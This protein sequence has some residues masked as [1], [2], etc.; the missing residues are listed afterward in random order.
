MAPSAAVTLNDA[1][2]QDESLVLSTVR[3]AAIRGEPPLHSGG[4]RLVIID[5][6]RALH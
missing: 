1:G 4:E 5:P 6:S 2:D 3:R